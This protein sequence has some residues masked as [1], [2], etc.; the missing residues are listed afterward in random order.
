MFTDVSRDL[1]EKRGWLRL[2]RKKLQTYETASTKLQRA[3]ECM[4]A[5]VYGGQYN[6]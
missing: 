1:K 3:W 4:E 2:L 6:W 5:T